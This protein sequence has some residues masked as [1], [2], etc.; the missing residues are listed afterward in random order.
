MAFLKPARYCLDIFLIVLTR[1]LYIPRQRITSR[2]SSSSASAAS[3]AVGHFSKKRS[4]IG[5][6]CFLLVWFSIRHTISIFQ[7]FGQYLSCSKSNGDFGGVH[8]IY[9]YWHGRDILHELSSPSPE[10]HSE[11]DNGEYCHCL[12]LKCL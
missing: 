8:A 4:I 9:Y 11:L 5:S 6:T 2:I 3:R 10:R 7:S 12:R 1:R